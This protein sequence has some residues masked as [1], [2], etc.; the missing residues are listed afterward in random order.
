MS[1]ITVI[2]NGYKRPHALEAQSNSLRRQTIKP[3]TVMF[4]Q[5]RDDDT[6]FDYSPL[7]GAVVTTSNANFG[8]WARFAYAL[9]A[10]TEYICV[11]DDDTVPGSKW[12][13]NC[14]NTIKETE[15]LLGA[16]GVVF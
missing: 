6:R 4:W 14:V 10:Q 7:N 3:H 8:V 2:L 1:D 16:I 5:N 15:G 9:N 11:L 13:E 12:L